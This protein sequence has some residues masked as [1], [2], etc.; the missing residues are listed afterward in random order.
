M[1]SPMNTRNVDTIFYKY[2]VEVH[3]FFKRRECVR[4]RKPNMI[5]LSRN[6]QSLHATNT[7]YRCRVI[8]CGEVRATR[9]V[10]AL[11]LSTLVLNKVHI[12]K[13]QF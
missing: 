10:L 3:S 8:Y 4:A 2:L 6:G 13:E 1:L 12:Y 5:K 11:Y 7:M 9:G